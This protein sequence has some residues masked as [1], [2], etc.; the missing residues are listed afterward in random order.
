MSREE[1]SPDD[2]SAK[3][4]DAFPDI[5]PPSFPVVLHK[6]DECD[7]VKAAFL[8]K[9]WS[10]ISLGTLRDH[11]CSLPLLSP[12][13][14]RYYLPAFLLG[15]IKDMDH[16]NS[17]LHT[18]AIYSLLPDGLV[19]REKCG[20]TVEQERAIIEFARWMASSAESAAIELYW[21][22]AA[23]TDSNSGSD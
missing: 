11:Y 20:F 22:C 6:C 19:R 17:S 1:T 10:E 3:I 2:L 23:K 13:A 12:E 18:F 8:G 21:S 9:R 4:R 7:Q 16:P 5:A 14:F 15:A